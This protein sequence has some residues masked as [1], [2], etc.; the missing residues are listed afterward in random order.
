MKKI[1]IIAVAVLLLA[2]GGFA[3][4]KFLLGG[5]KPATE[6]PEA[7]APASATPTYVALDPFVVP[8]IRDDRVARQVALTVK[9]ELQGGA[10]KTLV[11]EK[12]PL[13]RDAL[14]TRLHAV[15]SRGGLDNGQSF[16]AVRVKRQFLAEC[17]RVLGKGVVREV[18]IEEATEKIPR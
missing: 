8:V 2:A 7:A 15:L 17:D 5:G 4:W 11:N 12:M 13:L 1:A 10:A 9:L 6:T 3:A 14:L 18:L 16:D